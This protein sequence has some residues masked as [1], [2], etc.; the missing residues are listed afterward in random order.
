M[1]SGMKT[2]EGQLGTKQ[3]YFFSSDWVTLIMNRLVIVAG[4]PC[5][6]WCLEAVAGTA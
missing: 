5:K 2:P 4:R 3:F 1:F 6:N